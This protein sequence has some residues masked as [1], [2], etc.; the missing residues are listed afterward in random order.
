MP[1]AISSEQKVCL[2]LWGVKRAGSLAIF[3]TRSIE[4]RICFSALC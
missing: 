3:R 4:R 1:C 2:R